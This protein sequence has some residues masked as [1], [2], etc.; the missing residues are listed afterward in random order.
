[1]NEQEKEEL[2][3][4]RILVSSPG[5]RVLS[6]YLEQRASH[7]MQGAAN[8]ADAW[9]GAK[10]LGAGAAFHEVLTRPESFVRIADMQAAEG[11]SST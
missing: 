11:K 9:A 1:M 3:A 2:E 7:E 10:H 5:W 6:K 4:L 8:S